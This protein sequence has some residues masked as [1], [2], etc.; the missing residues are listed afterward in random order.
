MVRVLQNIL[1]LET[2]MSSEDLISV[3]LADFGACVRAVSC[4]VLWCVPSGSFCTM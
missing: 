3:K 1:I 4:V 2:A